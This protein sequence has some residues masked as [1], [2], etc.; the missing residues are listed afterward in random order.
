M[1]EEANKI[2]TD[3]IALPA[4]LV[5]PTKGIFLVIGQ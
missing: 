5:R 4:N 2:L 1:S 3:D